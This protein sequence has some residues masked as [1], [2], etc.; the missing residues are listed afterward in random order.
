VCG[1]HFLKNAPSEP[2]APRKTTDGIDCQRQN[3]N[4]QSENFGKT[5]T[6][7]YERDSFSILKDAFY[8]VSGE[9]ASGERAISA[10][11]ETV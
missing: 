5:C 1:G 3:S 11:L 9:Q 7:L 10:F 2:I 6:C 8:E 4:F